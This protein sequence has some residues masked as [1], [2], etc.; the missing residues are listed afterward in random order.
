MHLG[1]NGRVKG[2][3]AGGCKSTEDNACGL[4]NIFYL[5]LVLRND[6]VLTTQ[7]DKDLS[8]GKGKHDQQHPWLTTIR[9]FD[10]MQI[11]GT[12]QRMTREWQ[13]FHYTSNTYSSVREGSGGQYT[14]PLATP[15]L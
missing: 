13:Y 15:S 5:K 7:T 6:R 11:S 14:L 9:R 4:F 8:K 3:E 2:E 10:W 1:L 12:Q